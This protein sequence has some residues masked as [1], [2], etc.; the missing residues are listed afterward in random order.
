MRS[1]HPLLKWIQ[2]IPLGDGIRY[3]CAF[4]M[5]CF[6][7][8]YAWTL[9]DGAVARA[10][11]I[12]MRVFSYQEY[13]TWPKIWQYLRE[14]RTGV[15]PILSFLELWSFKAKG[16]LNLIA[17]GLYRVSLVGMLT[18]PLFLTRLRWIDLGIWSVS[19][20][21]LLHAL[22]VV[23]F[24]N[25]QL[26]DVCLPFFLLLF[27]VT[28][29]G[30]WQKQVPR[31]LGGILAAMSGFWLAMA[32]LARPFMLALV[33]ILIG[34]AAWQFW[35]KGVFRRIWILLIPVLL[36]SGG[37]HLKLLIYNNGQVIWSN[38]GGTN[39]FRAWV[40][41]V[42]QEAMR[43]QLQP[44]APPISDNDWAWTNINTQVHAENSAVRSA[45]VKK[46]ILAQPGAA[47]KLFWQKVEHFI[48]PQTDMYDYHP[49]TPAIPWYIKWVNW[50]YYV[51]AI[52]LVYRGIR[53]FW[54]PVRWLKP[55]F[56]YLFIAFFLSFLPII[57]EAGEEA[58]FLVA[59]VPFLMLV[60]HEG[61]HTL[62]KGLIWLRK[63]I[64][65]PPSVPLAPAAN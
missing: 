6:F 42:D 49:R 41:L 30:S 28:L 27:L 46:G 53:G 56:M 45:A 4:L 63:L 35:E 62:T 22:L 23:H 13:N 2:N 54:R 19:A 20:W 5:V 26:Y 14:L 44:E 48:E 50:T 7:V 15:P 36:L 61:G 60:L 10:A 58:R 65:P 55:G 37:W 21:L 57:G 34:Y 17:G 51:L 52:L 25:P 32:E 29:R 38:H 3:G 64:F 39:L 47:W 12:W 43:A 59:V 40:S 31:W 1:I 24:G 18:L 11:T 9:S 16:S 33:P 8:S